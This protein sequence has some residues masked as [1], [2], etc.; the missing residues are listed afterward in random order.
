MKIKRKKKMIF[1]FFTVSFAIQISLI[2]GGRED[3]SKIK[4]N[5][6]NAYK[7]FLKN[8]KFT[9]FV[10]GVLQF[11]NHDNVIDKI[12]NLDLSR[13]FM[14]CANWKIE[15]LVNNSYILSDLNPC[16]PQETVKKAQE[17]IRKGHV[18]TTIGMGKSISDEWLSKIC[19]PWSIRG[20]NWFSV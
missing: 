17:F 9:F 19:G 20:L 2:S 1:L 3:V 13:T 7:R 10:D 6:I 8:E 11:T 14:T 5:L 4:T 15:T 18:I 16:N 12:N